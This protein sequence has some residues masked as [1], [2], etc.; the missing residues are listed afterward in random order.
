[1]VDAPHGK[2]V[3]ERCRTLQRKLPKQHHGDS[4]VAVG[5]GAPG[6]DTP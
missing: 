6:G 4:V 5:G 2:I 1:M 3:G